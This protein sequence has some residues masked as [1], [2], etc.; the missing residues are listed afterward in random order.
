MSYKQ[1]VLRDNPIAFWPLNGTSSLRTYATIKLEYDTYQNWLDG[2]QTYGSDSLSFTLED[3]S[4]NQ[5]HGAYTLGS[6]AFADILPL[7]ALSNYDSQLNGCK[8]NNTSNVAVSNL[9]QL[10]N[11]FYT[12][13]EKLQFGIEF[14]LGFDKAPVGYSTILSINY[15]ENNIVLVY[16]ENDKICFAIGGVDKNTTTQVVYTAYKQIKTWDSQMHVFLSYSNGSISISVNSISGDVITLP[17]SFQFVYNKEQSKDFTYVLG[18][19]AFNDTD[20]QTP[21]EFVVNDLAFYDYVLSTNSIRS[22]MVWGT[23][24]S[25]PQNFVKETNGFFFDIKD[26]EGMFAFKKKFTSPKDYAQGNAVNLASDKTGLVL[27][28]TVGTNLGTWTYVIPSSGLSKIS[29]VKI[30]WDSGLQ[31]ET[32]TVTSDYLYVE[33]SQDN[34]VTWSQVKN[35][36]PIIKFADTSSVAYP[37]MLIRITISASTIYQNYLPRIDNL[38]I[39]VYKDMSIYSDA[40]AFALMPRQGSYTGDTYAIKTNSFN[41]L[42]R[43]ENFG[44]KLNKTIDGTN[45]V[46]AIYPQAQTSLFQTIEF[47]YRYDS[48]SSSKVQYILDTVG[49]TGYIYFG[50]DGGLYQNGFQNVY[51][52]GVDISSGRVLTEGEAYHFICVYQEPVSNIVYIG[53]DYSLTNYSLCTF[54]YLSI[55]PYA[56]SIG[57]AQ[58]RYLNFLTS[59][60]GQVDYP[61]ADSTVFGSFISSGY[62]PSNM[63]GTISDGGEPILAYVHPVAGG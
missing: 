6:P 63:I 60:V 38:F 41:I 55:Y 46:A 52:N 2:E 19:L 54:G 20:T 16:T 22:H 31:D 1:V 62:A 30:S 28:P 44:V 58:T 5:N 10:Y 57:N 18:Q 21:Y 40:G 61:Y 9:A 32:S 49:S 42:S 25:K 56:F 34:G 43:S 29:G 39:G 50:Q 17:D 11:M 4:S 59:T 47:W 33:I 12:G 36:Y 14:W 23:N 51:V 7:A 15:L 48:L 8:I 3:I 45:S 35:S 24:D 13:T 26:S 27:T 37:N 53:G